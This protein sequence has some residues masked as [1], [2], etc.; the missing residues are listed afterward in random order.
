MPV[1]NGLIFRI[2]GLSII[3]KRSVLPREL[4][5]QFIVNPQQKD[6][7]WGDVIRMSSGL[8]LFPLYVSLPMKIAALFFDLPSG[9]RTP[10]HNGP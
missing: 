5:Q 4:S 10:F 2:S 9:V 6:M 7:S 8:P 3:S 1:Q